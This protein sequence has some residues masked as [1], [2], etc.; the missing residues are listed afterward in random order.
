MEIKNIFL[1]H[2]DVKNNS[3][4]NI[5]L[6]GTSINLN[7]YIDSLVKEI[8]EQPN[9]REYNFKDGQTEIKSS[10]VSILDNVENLD[11][12]ILNNAKRLLEK[13]TKSQERMSR[14]DIEIQKGSLLHLHFVTDDINQII[15]CKVEHDEVLS[16]T[17]FDIIKGL[18]TKKKVFKAILVFFDDSNNITFNYVFDK[19]SSKYWWDDFLEL[20]QKNTDDKNTELSLNEIDKVLTPHRKKFYADFLIL[21]N[22]MI[23][24]YRNKDRFNYT[25][26]LDEVFR[27]YIPINSEFPKDKII[28]RLEE[29]PSKKG[30]DT[31]FV[32][33]KKKINKRA[34]HKIRLAH[35]LYL[36][37]DDYVENLKNLIE[38]VE[39]NG[40]KYVK[41]LSSDG[42]DFLK[43]LL[44]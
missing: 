20:I 10:L 33:T 2:I 19:N 44:K 37:I 25:E 30:F 38:P 16:E 9:K 17:N 13:E 22:S 4:S 15:I 35:N 3:V 12:L 43:D 26:L 8:L 42:Y 36:N 21:R 41:I 31:Q 24:H 5:E 7:S 6:D 27:N 28:K 11:S 39:E 29:L 40:S 1:H 14:L 18:N 34:Q 23:G 32:I